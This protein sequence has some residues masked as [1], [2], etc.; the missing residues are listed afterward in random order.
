M[1]IKLIISIFLLVNILSGSFA[2]NKR[3][4]K[5]E[6]DMEEAFVNAKNLVLRGKTDDAK[7]HLQIY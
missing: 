6:V 4:S 5:E 3:L 1:K 7:K 2:Q